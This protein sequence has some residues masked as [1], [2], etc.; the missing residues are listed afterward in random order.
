MQQNLLLACISTTAIY[1]KFEPFQAF[2]WLPC[3]FRYIPNGTDIDLMISEDFAMDDL[4]AFIDSFAMVS[5]NK[6]NH[7][8]FI[9]DCSVFKPWYLNYCQLVPL[10][11]DACFKSIS[12]FQ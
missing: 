12:S 10:H 6:T 2:L 1:K 11:L 8:N 7:C 4:L 9:H 5:S 3:N